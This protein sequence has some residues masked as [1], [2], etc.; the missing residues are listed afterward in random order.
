MTVKEFFKTTAFKCIAVLLSIVLICC[1]ALTICDSL[2]EV[3]AKERLDRAIAE[4]YG[5]SVEY[6]VA[7]IDED[8]GDTALYSID[9]LYD[10]SG[11][12]ENE[13]LMKITG[14]GGFNSGSVTCWV[15]ATVSPVSGEDGD[16]FEFGG[17]T[18]ATIDSNVNQSYIHY[19]TNDAIQ[20]VINKQDGD[21]FT[22]YDTNGIKTGATYSLG[23]IANALNGAK[24][25]VEAVYCGVVLPFDGYEYADRLNV[26]ETT[27]TVDGTNVNYHIVTNANSEAQPFTIEMTV[28]ADGAI[29]NYTIIV[30]G[31]TMDFGSDMAAIALNMNGQTLETL[32]AFVNSGGISTGA[33]RSNE[34]CVYA[35]LFATANYEKALAEFSQGGNA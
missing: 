32:E 19:I 17:I 5:E 3:T 28:G 18:K 6:T 13:F 29:S 4:I 9:E 10:L 26:N 8:K 24:E 20:A 35:G 22:S 34:A 2:F 25:Y 16:G 15:V 14:K 23:S 12:H 1:I 27:V 30:N 7:E 11:K 33:T 21:G 31:S